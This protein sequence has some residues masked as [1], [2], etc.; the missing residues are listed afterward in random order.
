MRLVL[1]TCC[2]TRVL[3]DHYS[4]FGYG[5]WSLLMLLG[6]MRDMKRLLRYRTQQLSNRGANNAP[7]F[8][9]SSATKSSPSLLPLPCAD[10]PPSFQYSPQVHHF[11]LSHSSARKMEDPRPNN[12][13]VT[14]LTILAL[15][16]LSSSLA[17]EALREIRLLEKRT[18]PSSEAFDFSK[19]NVY[20][21]NTRV[22]CVFMNRQYRDQLVAYAVCVRARKALLLHK[23][24]VA[25]QCRR[26]GI[27]NM[28]LAHLKGKAEAQRCRQIDLWVDE[29]RSPARALYE[30][31][32][33]RVTGS[34]VRDYY[35]LGRN[36]FNMVCY[37]DK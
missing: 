34:L 5:T 8:C 18:F 32:G 11:F 22:Y 29:A 7:H 19:D 21:Q 33:F 2:G 6:K 20:K 13:T 30:S 36:A 3:H 15:R 14:D 12:G 24:C 10:I 4:Y 35:G 31:S 26:Q 23:I 17:E 28:L 27:G 1:T 16:D 37:L 25:E 9:P